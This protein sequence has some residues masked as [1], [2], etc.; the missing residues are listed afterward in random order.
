MTRLGLILVLFGTCL[1]FGLLGAQGQSNSVLGNIDCGG[2]QT[3]C[4]Q[5]RTGTSGAVRCTCT[6]DC[7]GNSCIAVSI[8]STRALQ[9]GMPPAQPCLFSVTGTATGGTTVTTNPSTQTAVFTTNSITGVVIGASFTKQVVD[10][11][12]GTIQDDPLIR[13]LC[14]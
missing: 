5:Q 8:A 11:F 7:L 2:H 1:G 13:S 4:F 9:W 3:T 6:A 14:A 10:C 12:A